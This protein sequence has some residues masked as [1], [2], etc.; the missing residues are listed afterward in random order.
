MAIDVDVA[1]NP[2]VMHEKGE[3]TLDRQLAP[4]Y[5]RIAEFMLNSPIGTEQSVIPALITSDRNMTATSPAGRRNRVAE[6]YDRLVI[7]NK[8]PGK[9]AL[10]AVMRKLLVTANAIARDRKPWA[11]AA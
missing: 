10:T 9:V 5:H 2:F 8:R 4:V 11:A 1:K 6:Y 7:E 3:G